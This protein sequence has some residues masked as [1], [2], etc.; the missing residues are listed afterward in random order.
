MGTDRISTACLLVILSQLYRPGLVFVSLSALD[1]GSQWLQMYS[2]FLTGK[3]SHKD[4]KDSTNW[5]FKAYYGNGMFMGYCCVVC[6]LLY[7]ILFLIAEKQRESLVDVVA[8]AVQQGSPL[9]FLVALSLFAWVQ[10]SKRLMSYRLVTTNNRKDIHNSVIEALYG[11]RRPN[12]SG[13]SLLLKG[14]LLRQLV[15]CPSKMKTAADMCV[16]YDIEKKQK[17]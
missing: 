2:T 14:K 12:L 8:S 10:S 17:P 6:E 4:A 16:P 11:I 7:L 13:I 9:S 1:I 15:N 5:L 3:T